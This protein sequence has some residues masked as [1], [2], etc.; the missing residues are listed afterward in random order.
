MATLSEEIG[1]IE[2]AAAER[3]VSIRSILKRAS[4]APSNW[5][6]WKK[7]Q[8]SPSLKTWA[9]VTSAADSLLSEPK[10]PSPDNTAAHGAGSCRHPTPDNGLSL[11][12][13]ER[14]DQSG[15]DSRGASSASSSDPQSVAPAGAEPVS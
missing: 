12:L 9:E 2:R 3:S 4:L 8:T 13:A 5:A 15:A 11:Q 1:R 6:R 7:G 14:P 10:T